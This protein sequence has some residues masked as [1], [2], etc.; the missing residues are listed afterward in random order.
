MVNAAVCV[1]RLAEEEHARAKH[2]G[3]EAARVPWAARQLPR[4]RER[5]RRALST[6]PS[7]ERLLA[8]LQRAEV[9]SDS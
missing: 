3:G 5:V 2:A 7:D 1:V 4:A 9:L 8:L 6:A